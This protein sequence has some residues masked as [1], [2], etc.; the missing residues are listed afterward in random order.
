M[1]LPSGG[2]ELGKKITTAQMEKARMLRG[3]LT[4]VRCWL[5][6]F[7]AGTGKSPPGADSLRQSI[8]FLDEI[9][10]KQVPDAVTKR[11]A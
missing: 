3:E 6:G 4:K 11:R 7:E 1:L 2:H 8:I 5:T 10:G 9:V